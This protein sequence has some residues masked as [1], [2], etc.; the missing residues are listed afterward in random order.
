MT[1]NYRKNSEWKALY[2]NINVNELHLLGTVIIERVKDSLT[3]K[4][5]KAKQWEL[6]DIVD[7]IVV[8][9]NSNPISQ[10]LTLELLVYVVD[11]TGK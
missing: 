5:E 8:A 6:I 4:E 9:S 3:P 10:E 2:L 1:V 7:T 11:M